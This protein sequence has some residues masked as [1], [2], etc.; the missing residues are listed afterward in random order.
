MYSILRVEETENEVSRLCS[1]K[2]LFILIYSSPL[3]IAV[4]QNNLKN[5]LVL[6][7]EGSDV[8]ATNKD[9][10]TPLHFCAKIK[11]IEIARALIAAG[12]KFL[13]KNNRK[14]TPLSAAKL[15]K[16]NQ[17]VDLIHS[18]RNGDVDRGNLQ[19]MLTRYL[20]EIYGSN[21]EEEE[22]DDDDDDDSIDIP[23]KKK[24]K[25]SKSHK[26][27]N[28][29]QKEQTKNKKSSSKS[30]LHS[31]KSKR[32]PSSSSSDDSDIDP[33]TIN[34]ILDGIK[35]LTERVNH[36]YR[37]RNIPIDEFSA[38]NDKNSS[39]EGICENIQNLAGRIDKLQ[40][41]PIE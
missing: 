5:V 17:L 40:N 7:E 30:K 34:I 15:Y 41:N 18:I 24:T 8:N 38:S 6:L 11:N 19:K 13:T 12:A 23:T 36:I 9:G 2:V 10:N 1:D 14:E 3:H 32:R 28:K 26:S 31:K 25:S 4:A 22:D 29:K 20:P 16:F 37:A 21:E 35:D 33:K 39:I 27:S